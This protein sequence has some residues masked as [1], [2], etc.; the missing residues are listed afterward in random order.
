MIQVLLI[1]QEQCY[2]TNITYLECYKFTVNK[3]IKALRQPRARVERETKRSHLSSQGTEAGAT[4]SLGGE[5]S[6]EQRGGWTIGN[7]GF[8]FEMCSV[9]IEKILGRGRLVTKILCK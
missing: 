7:S 5:W 2:V 3:F 6:L 9:K 1:Y 4:S 8:M